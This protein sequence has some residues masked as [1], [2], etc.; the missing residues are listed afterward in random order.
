MIEPPKMSYK[1][2]IERIGRN[3]ADWE[4]KQMLRANESG[5]AQFLGGKDVVDDISA[6]NAILEHKAEVKRKFK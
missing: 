6:I 4:L 1:K 5:I 3:R 2:A